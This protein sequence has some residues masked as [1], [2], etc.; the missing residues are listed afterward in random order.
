MWMPCWRIIHECDSGFT[1]FGSF[2]R[3]F[4]GADWSSLFGMAEDSGDFYILFDGGRFG[5]TRCESGGWNGSL[6]LAYRRLGGTIWDHAGRRYVSG[7]V[8]IAKR[9][10]CSNGGG[11][12]V[13]R[14]G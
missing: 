8:A 6:G 4:G 2:A 12:C 1:D 3:R 5:A 14:P 10:A 11:V 13:W 9:G 7:G